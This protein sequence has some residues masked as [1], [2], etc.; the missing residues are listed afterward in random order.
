MLLADACCCMGVLTGSV[1][2][3][4]QVGGLAV[5]V[6]LHVG[7]LAHGGSLQERVEVDATLRRRGRGLQLQLHKLNGVLRL[8]EE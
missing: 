4:R 6:P 2:L 1:L 8:R 7:G 3:H 5:H